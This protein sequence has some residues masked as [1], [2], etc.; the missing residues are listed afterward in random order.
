MRAGVLESLVAGFRYGD[1]G[2]GG[3]DEQMNGRLGDEIAQVGEADGKVD[4]W[5]VGSRYE[6]Q[7]CDTDKGEMTRLLGF[8]GLFDML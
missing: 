8:E 4:I 5:C 3:V 2:R 7:E 1:V 6:W